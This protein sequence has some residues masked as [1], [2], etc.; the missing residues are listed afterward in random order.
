MSPPAPPLKARTGRTGRG[1]AEFALVIGGGVLLALSALPVDTF[2]VAQAE[3]VSFEVLNET[4]VLPFVIVWP[5]M[6]LGNVLVVPV[7]ALIAAV[8]RKWRLSAGILVGGLGVYLL[9]KGV[10]NVVIRGRPDE[11]LSGVDIRGEAAR[12][13]GFVSGHA[14]VVTVIVVLLW[15]YLGWRARIIV[16]VLAVAVSLSRVYVGAHLPLDILGG[17]G[18]G[19]AV[20]GAVRL[21]LGRPATC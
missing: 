5:V 20:G 7:A 1:W 17:V 9:A 21:A 10:K 19:L 14:A 2:R 15:P 12:G 8:R 11:L 18:L 4:T 16:T 6:Q 13:S 3:R